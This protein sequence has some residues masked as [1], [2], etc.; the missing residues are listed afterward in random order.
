MPSVS[1]ESNID[2]Y[3]YRH[4]VKLQGVR[5]R[6]RSRTQSIDGSILHF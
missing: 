2:R 1:T 5:V 4:Q 6:V 3:G